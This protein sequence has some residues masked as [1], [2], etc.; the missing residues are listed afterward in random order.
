MI[1]PVCFGKKCLFPIINPLLSALDGGIGRAHDLIR[2]I[3][4]G[5]FPLLAGLYANEHSPETLKPIFYR[6]T[7]DVSIRM[8]H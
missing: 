3:P 1:A 2:R 5:G 6:R 4:V 8:R 7:R